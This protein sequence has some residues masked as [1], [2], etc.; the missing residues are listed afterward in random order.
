MNERVKH[1]DVA[2]GISIFLVALFHSGLGNL[3]PAITEPM[4][5]FRIPLFFFLSGVF[6]SFDT[7]PKDFLIKKFESLLKPYF[8]VLFTILM[9]QM[10]IG[11]ENISKKFYGILYGTGPTILDIWTALWFLTHLFAVY[12]FSFIVCK[13]I[14][15]LN[16]SWATK[17]IS[18]IFIL[19]V[20]SLF[21]DL[22]WNVEI[23]ILSDSYLLL[24]LPFSLDIVFIT[25]SY[26]ILGN[27]LRK[28]II[29][30]SPNKL[31]AIFSLFMFLCIVNFTDAHTN[32]NER[33]FSNPIFATVGAI[34]GIYMVLA[35]SWLLSRKQ[36]LSFI[37]LT[38]GKSSL[39]IL[40]F[41]VP[42]NHVIANY[43]V[44][45][46]SDEK[47]LIA[48][49]VVAFLLSISLPLAIKWIV[50]RNSILSLAF[51]PIR[52]NKVIQKMIKLRLKNVS[53][54]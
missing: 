35:I 33:S 32:L 25:A 2:K 7:K 6:F 14:Q 28:E 53:N 46:I 36:S 26:F 18:L 43:F 51:F 20:S 24:G 21:I 16:L 17:F 11:D 45:I 34:F 13:L 30:F 27:L 41:H 37:P 15:P 38:L 47:I 44:S 3:V 49:R 19:I 9:I 22:F 23:D 40:I 42:I 52:S 12:C 29:N 5:L 4:S 10:L 39:F 8:V 54:Y 50:V 1:I 48:A 31:V